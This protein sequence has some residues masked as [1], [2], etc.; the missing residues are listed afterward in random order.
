MA[1][2]AKMKT[3]IF[4]KLPWEW[5]FHLQNKY[6]LHVKITSTQKGTPG[7]SDNMPYYT[8]QV[9]KDLKGNFKGNENIDLTAGFVTSKVDLN[10][11]YLVLVWGRGSSGEPDPATDIINYWLV[12]YYLVRGHSTNK[13]AFFPIV[14]NTII[15]KNKQLRFDKGEIPIPEFEA[16]VKD[17]IQNTAGV[18]TNE[19]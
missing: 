4:E 9:I 14:N 13:E 10:S 5:S 11:E 7:R 16:S 8:C 3:K 18:N 6:L 15:D 2:H 19:N 1:F 12:D 17:F